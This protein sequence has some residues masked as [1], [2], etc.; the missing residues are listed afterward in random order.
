MLGDLGTIS[1]DGFIS[2]TGRVKELYKLENGKY[3]APAA[4]EEKVQLSPYI[5]QAMVFGANHAYNVAVMVPKLDNLKEWAVAH[6]IDTAN[7][8]GLLTNAQVKTL[9]RTEIDKHAA[10]FK[11]KGFLEDLRPDD[12]AI[13][14]AH[15]LSELNAIHVFREGNGRAQLTFFAILADNPGHPLDLERL[16]PDEMLDAMIES[17]EG[18]ESRLAGV[19]RE[20]VTDRRSPQ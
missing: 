11:A 6:R 1:A 14:A 20:L 18:D 3:V 7:M 10:D 19:I 12:F 9:M 15:F 8:K 2:I 5:L 17:F 4:L 16:D 13:Q